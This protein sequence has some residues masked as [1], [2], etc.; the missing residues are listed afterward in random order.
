M[1]DDRTNRNGNNWNGWSPGLSNG[2]SVSAARRERQLFVEII[3]EKLAKLDS[4]EKLLV[5]ASKN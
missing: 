2:K 5:T 3:G 1:E 4:V